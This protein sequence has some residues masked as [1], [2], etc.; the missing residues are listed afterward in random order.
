MLS[1]CEEKSS[2][3]F[4]TPKSNSVKKKKYLPNAA[5]VEGFRQVS[6]G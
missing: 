2:C 4:I 3:G 6:K 5:Q 1:I